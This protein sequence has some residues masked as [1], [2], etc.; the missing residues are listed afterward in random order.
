MI[1]CRA[2]TMNP[3]GIIIAIIPKRMMPPPIPNTA[4]ID[5]VKNAAKIRTIDSILINNNLDISEN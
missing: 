3:S 2:I 4:E 5:E 1:P